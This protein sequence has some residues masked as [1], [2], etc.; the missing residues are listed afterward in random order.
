MRIAPLLILLVVLAA[1]GPGA[2]PATTTSA[3]TTPINSLPGNTTSG[4][5]EVVSPPG[6]IVSVVRVSDGDSFAASMAE[7]AE[8]EVRLLGINAPEGSECFGDQSRDALES[9]LSSGEVT[10]VTDAETTDQFNRDLRYVYVNGLNINHEMIATGHALVLQTDHTLDA[11]FVSTGD[12]A[13]IRAVG[14]WAPDA[15]G[16]DAPPPSVTIADYVFD[17]RGRD[18]DDLNGEWVAIANEGSAAV[19]MTK[20]ILRDESTQNRFE[21]PGGFSLAPGD[22]VL[23]HSGC[24]T[25]TTADL[26]W[27]TRDPVWSNGG[28]TVILLQSYGAVVAW[29][30]YL[31]NF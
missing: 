30:R 1:C 16:G 29:K 23:V 28:D 25:A 3:V 22:Q 4:L 19:D 2:D 14:M 5:G 7:G 27:C 26:F 15:C 24:G 18:A 12:D 8:I 10:L 31:G 11:E 13:A 20:W 17:P 6:D 9:W 21:F